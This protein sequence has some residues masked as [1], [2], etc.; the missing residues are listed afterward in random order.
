M[1]AGTAGLWVFSPAWSHS[2]GWGGD[3]EQNL[4]SDFLPQSI[5]GVRP[6]TAS[7]PFKTY[8]TRGRPL[9]HAH[10]SKNADWFELEFRVESGFDNGVLVV[11]LFYGRELSLFYLYGDTV[12]ELRCG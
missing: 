2:F 10:L 7:G 1:P 11:K 5:G 8:L 9:L 3:H 12:R 4:S 6:L